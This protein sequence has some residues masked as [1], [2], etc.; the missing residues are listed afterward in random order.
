MNSITEEQVVSLAP[1]AA[2]LK[3][4]KALAVENKWLT[5]AFNDR[6][7]WG[8]VQG[9][10]KDP[11]RTQVD[12]GQMA[13][14]CSCP[15][16]K[17][18]CKH[19]LGLLLLFAKP[20]P[21]F[22]SP[23]EEPAWVSEWM[24]KRQTKAEK[25]A[26]PVVASP[27][28]DEQK[29][30]DRQKRQ[31]ERL[32]KVQGGVTELGQWLRDM[33]R[34]G[35]LNVPERGYRHFDQTAARMVDAQAT[36]LAN[37]VK[38]FNA[39]PYA[40]SD[41]QSQVLEQCTKL[42]VWTEAFKNLD[43]L[44]IPVQEDIKTALGWNRSAKD[45]DAEGEVVTDDWLVLGRL[46]REEERI[47]VQQNW[48][49]GHQTNRIA[50]VLNFAYQN[51]GIETPLV[52]G[53]SSR[54]ELRFFPSAFPFRAIVS[55]HSG[56]STLDTAPPAFANWLEAEAFLNQI[57]LA[58]PWADQI[59]LWIQTVSLV[60]VGDQWLLRD[61]ENRVVPLSEE[62]YEMKIFHLLALG[63]GNPLTLSVRYSDGTVYPLGIWLDDQYQL[64][65]S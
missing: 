64:L 23:P 14:K 4:G 16:R 55:N 49:W 42:F 10:G 33:V 11:Y 24:D 48:L 32:R 2:S 62:F 15:S 5:L 37:A 60:R 43:S 27:A 50:L 63:G 46:T 1:D 9:S 18:P 29:E 53:T 8:E 61:T 12:L 65:P 34:T 39:I 7:L 51:A 56:Y 35:T 36:G 30:K 40:G 44:P 26:E 47:T 25:A 52:P 57:W 6:V 13:S 31:Q 59:P 21:A 58:Q 54:A 45:L 19:G 20:S 28:T 17:F 3:A 41:W 22:Q 38:A